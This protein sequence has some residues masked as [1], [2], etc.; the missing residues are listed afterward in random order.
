MDPCQDSTR[1][2]ESI[3]GD[4]P[5]RREGQDHHAANQ[6]EDGTWEL[7]AERESPLQV[8][9]E[10]DATVS[11][12]VGQEETCGRAHPL[13]T[14]DYTAVL[15]LGDL[16]HVD[17]RHR[18]DHTRRPA[19]QQSPGDKHADIGTNHGQQDAHDGDGARNCKSVSAAKF[20][21]GPACEEGSDSL[22]GVVD[23]DDGTYFT[24]ILVSALSI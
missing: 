13:E 22:A 7:Q 12:P 19:G 15:G 18:Q 8:A 20:V 16:G 6:H 23:R 2:F 14:D 5:T 9:L 10:E 21:G 24:A 3:L 17:G 4:K 1:L 11:D